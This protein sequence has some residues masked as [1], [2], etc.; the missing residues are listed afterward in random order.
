MTKKLIR[1]RS[2]S[3]K[4]LITFRTLSEH[5]GL[6]LLKKNNKNEFCWYNYGDKGYFEYC[7]VK[8][9]PIWKKLKDAE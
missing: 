5:C 2:V 6:K 3:S 1:L 7:T 4:K 9:C 8:T